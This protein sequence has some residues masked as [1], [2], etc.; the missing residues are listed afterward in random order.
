MYVR[1]SSRLLFLMTILFTGAACSKVKDSETIFPKVSHECE[2]AS[3]KGRYVVR[4]SNGLVTLHKGGDRQQVMQEFVEK[5]VETLD[6]VEPDYRVS[7]PETRSAGN[8]PT[9]QLGSADNWGQVRMNA[10]AAWTAGNYGG[11]ITVAVIDSGMDTTHPQL[12]NQLA[13]NPGEIAGNGIDDDHNGFID[14]V[15]GFDFTTDSPAVHDTNSHGTHVSGI[16]AAEHHDTSAGSRDYVQGVAPMAKI[17]PLTF[18][19]QSGSGS[20]YDAMRAIDYAS[21][22]GAQVIN[23]SWGGSACSTIMRDQV[24]ALY[25]KRIIFVA[26][27]G[28]SGMNIDLAPEYPAAFNV[29]S[30]ITVGAT[31]NFDSRAQFSNYG[32]QGVHIFAPGVDIVSTLPNRQIGPMSGTSMATPM[33]AGAVAL[34]LSAKPNVTMEQLRS[35][36][37]QSAHFDRSYRNASQ[38]RFDLGAAL[39]RLLQ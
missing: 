1:N 28:N 15:A 12:Q 37:Y 3:I 32:D 34:L 4:W 14:D 27:A 19:D 31:G 24:G 16:I 30:Q 36:I 20:L 39:A 8:I 7:T 9:A 10:S 26:A 38:G 18:I 25:A 17:L 35:V 21:Q 6:L 29:L 33:V 23:A 2:D 22:R 11:G 13:K 5:N